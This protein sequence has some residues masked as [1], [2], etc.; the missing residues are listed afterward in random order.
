MQNPAAVIVRPP[1]PGAPVS[2][3]PFAYWAAAIVV[4]VTVATAPLFMASGV[5]EDPW[6]QATK[7]QSAVAIAA[8]ST[9]LRMIVIL[10]P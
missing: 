6:P 8:A 9:A 4:V 10:P 7:P 5:E 1:R 2:E 3:A